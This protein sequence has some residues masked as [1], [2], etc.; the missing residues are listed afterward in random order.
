MKR[1]GL[2]I[3]ALLLLA[4][5]TAAQTSRRAIDAKVETETVDI[6]R[7]LICDDNFARVI[8]GI[9][10]EYKRCKSFNMDY[11]FI[12]YIKLDCVADRKELYCISISQSLFSD[13]T[14]EG[15]GF[16]DYKGIIFIV[17]GI[18]L[19]SLFRKTHEMRTTI[20]YKSDQ[21]YIFDP[22]RWLYVYDGKNML[23]IYKSPCGG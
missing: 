12:V 1:K 16:F 14:E 3:I 19:T 2:I 11:P 15:Y 10:L 6:P 5:T 9:V 18:P 20:V 22:P 4:F 8:D 23:E 17:R 13:A 21:S 7:L